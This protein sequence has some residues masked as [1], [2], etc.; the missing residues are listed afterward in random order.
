ME[1]R[2]NQ[3]LQDRKVLWDHRD[4]RDSKEW[5]DLL[6][7]L[8][9]QDLKACVDH[10]DNQ[11]PRGHR[12]GQVAKDL[13]EHRVRKVPGER[14]D[15][16]VSQDPRENQGYRVS[17]ARTDRLD[18]QDLRER[19]AHKESQVHL[20]RKENEDPRVP[21]VLLEL[22]VLLEN[23][24]LLVQPVKQAPRALPV[25]EGRKEMKE[26][27]DYPVL[28]DLRAL[29][30]FLVQEE[31]KE[32]ADLADHRDHRA[33]LDHED[34]Q[35]QQVLRVIKESL[36]IPEV[37]ADQETRETKAPRVMQELLEYPA[38]R[39]DLVWR[40]RRVIEVIPGHRDLP[41]REV[42][43]D[44]QGHKD[45]WVRWD[46][47]ARKDPQAYKV[48]RE[49]KAR[50]GKMETPVHRE[51]GVPPALEEMTESP[52]NQGSRES[53]DL[54]DSLVRMVIR[55]IRVTQDHQDP[56]DLQDLQDHRDREATEDLLE[57]EDPPVPR[58]ILDHKDHLELKDHVVIRV[59]KE[60]K[61]IK[62]VKG[63]KEIRD[64]L[65]SLVQLELQVLWAIRVIRVLQDRVGSQALKATGEKTDP[66]ALPA[67]QDLPG[68]GEE[69]A[70]RVPKEIEEL[71][72]RGVTLEIQDHPG[73]RDL[74]ETLARI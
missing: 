71:K 5:K 36:V 73:H 67:H 48:P 27:E 69:L 30:V 49:L 37:M 20:E 52:V 6:V 45:Q 32:N 24:G 13:K 12:G 9:R 41:G 17:L 39:V 44:H 2:V 57:T 70:Y 74:L 4:P 60:K 38:L 42:L 35:G 65:V 19:K 28:P 66:M 3:E 8:E 26:S 34:H 62:V 22:L 10:Q 31:R 7:S 59:R 18:H 64:G 58:V 55:A 68:K 43:P 15:I 21:L 61:E 11:V 56:E 16:A 63:R 1:H 40:A 46:H 33:Y 29:R 53:L 72:E 50:T 47:Q 23:Q 25:R 51:L 14:K 54:V